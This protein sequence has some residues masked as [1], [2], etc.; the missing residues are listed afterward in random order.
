MKN[1][2]FSDSNAGSGFS[3]LEEDSEDEYGTDYGEDENDASELRP[4]YIFTAAFT[5]LTF[6]ILK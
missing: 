2:C 6:F 3:D 5:I 4:R 1:F